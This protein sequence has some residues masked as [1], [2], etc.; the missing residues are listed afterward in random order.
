MEASMITVTSLGLVG[1]SLILIVRNVNK[2]MAMMITIV[3]SVLI[4]MYTMTCLQS[5]LKQFSSYFSALEAG[6]QY[7]AILIK[8]LLISYAADL[9]AQL[10]RDAGE[11]SIA[12]KVELAGK[13]V[14]FLT[15]S[16]VIF[17]V[18]E[19]ISQLIS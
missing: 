13:V 19:L 14:M 8:V 16:P 18:I 6:S 4:L 10:C 1:L 7:Y 9:T 5:L 15:A 11:S 3:I 12:G 2:E 17:S